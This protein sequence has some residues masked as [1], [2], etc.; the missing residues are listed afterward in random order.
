MSL[1][2]KLQN[3]IKYKINNV[4]S[5]PAADTYAAEQKQKQ[6]Q[7][8]ANADASKKIQEVTAK[9]AEE[10]KQAALATPP[11]DTQ[12][13]KNVALKVFIGLVGCVASLALGSMLANA[14]IHRHIAL[15]ILNFI[16]GS[17][18]GAIITMFAIGTSGFILIFFAPI[19]AVLYLTG[20]I[21]HMFAFLPIT[22]KKPESSVGAFFLWPFRWDINI[23]EEHYKR[24]LDSYNAFKTAGLAIATGAPLL[25]PEPVVP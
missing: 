19:L 8:Q 17:V 21:P 7:E 20:N 2:E 25:V 22:H 5:D 15:R 9:A 10:K 1:L 6:E 3:T 11:T 24:N 23:H 14:S 4:V 16:Y 13:A 18:I 12:T